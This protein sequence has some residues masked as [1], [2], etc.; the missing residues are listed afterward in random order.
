MSSTKYTIFALAPLLL[1]LEASCKP[2]IVKR[3]DDPPIHSNGG[4]SSGIS[5]PYGSS[6]STSAF[7]SNS[8]SMSDQYGYPAPSTDGQQSYP[9]PVTDGSYTTPSTDGQQSY[10][11]P[12]TDSQQGYPTSADGQLIYTTAAATDASNSYADTTT[13]FLPTYITVTTTV[14]QQG[15]PNPT[16][17]DQKTYPTSSTDSQQ[18]NTASTPDQH[19]YS[20]PGSDQ[21][22]SSTST[23]T[24]STHSRSS[25][26][27]TTTTTSSTTT[28]AEY[29][30]LHSTDPDTIPQSSH[31]GSTSDIQAGSGPNGGE[32]WFN[33]GMDGAGWNPPMLNIRDVKHISLEEFYSN[34]GG[35][36]RQFDSHFKAAHEK[37]GID[38]VF[39]AVLAM[40]ESSCNAQATGPTPGLMQ[41]ACGNYVE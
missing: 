11:T 16:S 39:Y 9:T 10:S 6:S 36:C 26:S 31:P 2:L 18:T 29:K 3:C 22:S 13:V 17:D 1:A 34:A 7:Y 19:S 30:S 21:T 23:S 37:Y 40:Q 25:T 35:A 15:N 5:D 28:S 38:P 20:H 8:S 12:I 32:D 33:T 41:V 24:H 4:Y 27:A 14:I